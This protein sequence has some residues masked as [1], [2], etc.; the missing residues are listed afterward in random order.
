M[1]HSLEEIAARAMV[2]R[3][4]IPEFPSQVVEQLSTIGG[5]AAPRKTPAF[6]DLR[7]RFWISIDNEDSRDLDQ[8][9]FAEGNRI[10]V[11][12][13]DVDGIVQKGSPIDLQ[14]SHNTTSVYTPARV[15]PML[16]L[17]LSNDLTSL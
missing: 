8:L 2:E 6:R 12:I 14:A 4:F 15:F 9:T 16:P 5:P 3:G 10:F 11:A 13:A 17:K 7:D 1:T